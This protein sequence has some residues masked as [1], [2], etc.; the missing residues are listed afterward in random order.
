M[1]CHYRNC[2]RAFLPSRNDKLYCCDA[3]KN[4][5]G[6]IRFR[7]RHP[8]RFK[9]WGY[10]GA[11]ERDIRYRQTYKGK[12][13]SL[14]KSA[15]SRNLTFDLSFQQFIELIKD[16]VC[17]WC[18]G[19]LNPLG[20]GIDRVDPEIGYEINNVVPCRSQCNYAK[21][22]YSQEEFV[23]WIER[24]YRFQKEGKCVA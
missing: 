13:A 22:D 14:K 4:L 24:V 20:Y 9:K 19:A 8:E 6:V 11:R 16:K 7:E 3:H 18:G 17:H 1:I 21:L 5:E 10:T 23:S 2:Q 15:V 12:Y